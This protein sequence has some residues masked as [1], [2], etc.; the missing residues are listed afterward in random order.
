ML[1]VDFT[2]KLDFFCSKC[3]DVIHTRSPYKV[4]FDRSLKKQCLFSKV[5]KFKPKSSL[6]V[7]CCLL[8]V[9]KLMCENPCLY[10]CYHCLICLCDDILIMI[11]FFRTYLSAKRLRKESVDSQSVSS[12]PAIAGHYL[13]IPSFCPFNN[14]C[15]GSVLVKILE[16]ATMPSSPQVSD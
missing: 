15:R 9:F 6:I 11:N 16:C 10:L 1:K 13:H 2:P 5:P 8:K 3:S 14:P 7:Q 12:M 4:C